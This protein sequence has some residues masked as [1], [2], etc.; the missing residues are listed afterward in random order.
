GSMFGIT[1]GKEVPE[2]SQF[3]KSW[4]GDDVTLSC[5]TRTASSKLKA[6]FYKGGLLKESSSTANMTIHNVSTSDEGLYK[7]RISGAGESADSLM[8]VR[9]GAVILES[10]ALPVMEGDTVTLR[11]RNKKTT[12]NYISDF[13][14]DSSQIETGYTGSMTLHNV[15]KSDEGFYKCVIPGAGESAESWLSVRGET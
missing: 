1:M 2:D 12:S 5:R 6:D 11:C 9:G 13:Y 4:Q 15:S 14:K 8:S 3:F 10:P 7:C